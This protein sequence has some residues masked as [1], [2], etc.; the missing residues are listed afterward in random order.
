LC[1][2]RATDRSDFDSYAAILVG[3]NAEVTVQS[4]CIVYEERAA[5]VVKRIRDG[6]YDSHFTKR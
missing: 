3:T 6:A 2:I 1:G 4:G 5:E